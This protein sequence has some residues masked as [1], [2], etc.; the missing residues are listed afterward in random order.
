MGKWHLTNTFFKCENQLPIQCQDLWAFDT[1][2]KS[3]LPF[4]TTSLRYSQGFI[5]HL[6]V[7]EIEA[8]RFLEVRIWWTSRALLC[9]SAPPQRS[10]DNEKQTRE[11][12]SVTT[13]GETETTIYFSV[14]F[15]PNL[16]IERHSNE[17]MWNSKA[18]NYSSVW[19]SWSAAVHLGLNTTRGF[20]FF[21]ASAKIHT[22][23]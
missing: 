2:R 5:K 1:G 13:A 18:M 4:W 14:E 7:W 11:K 3:N 12:A 19:S 9:S 16:C 6:A 10:L 22:Q 8:E 20:F 21:W 15:Q 17:T 23:T